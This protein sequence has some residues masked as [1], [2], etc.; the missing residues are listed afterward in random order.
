MPAHIAHG[1]FAEEAVS[2]FLPSNRQYYLGRYLNFLTFGAQGP[3]IFYHNQRRRPRSLQFG[4]AFH[5]GGYGRFLSALLRLMRERN[6]DLEESE[7][8]YLL[9]FLTHAFLDRKLHPYIIYHSGWTRDPKD[10]LKRYS[11]VFME[12]ILDVLL[13]Q[14]IKGKSIEN[15]DFFSRVDIRPGFRKEFQELLVDAVNISFPK[16]SPMLSLQ[17]LENAFFDTLSFLEFSNPNIV[18]QG[19]EVTLRMVSL[20]HPREI[21]ENVDWMNESRRS[22][23]HYSRGIEFTS[24]VA[25]LY[26]E[27]LNACASVMGLFDKLIAAPS[28]ISDESL[29]VLEQQVGNENLNSGFYEDSRVVPLYSEPLPVGELMQ[30]IYDSYWSRQGH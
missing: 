19:W 14:K 1:L 7:H 8:A 29:Y 4:K 18:W 15:F 3:D 12:R 13:L 20:S 24:S 6:F 17:S 16:T 5:Q 26:K 21:P 25:D 9:G 2:S 30:D 23:K 11:H 22:W 28:D 27:A 10:Y